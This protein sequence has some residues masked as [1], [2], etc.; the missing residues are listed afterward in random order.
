MEQP[1]RNAIGVIAQDGK[2]HGEGTSV[3]DLCLWIDKLHFGDPIIVS[4]T[5]GGESCRRLAKAE[6]I[7]YLPQ[8]GTVTVIGFASKNGTYPVWDGGQDTIGSITAQQFAKLK[9]W[10]L[11]QTV[12][13]HPCFALRVETKYQPDFSLQTGGKITFSLP[14]CCSCATC[15]STMDNKSATITTFYERLSIEMEDQEWLKWAHGSEQGVL[16]AISDGCPPHFPKEIIRRVIY[17]F[18]FVPSS[19]LLTDEIKRLEERV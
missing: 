1:E 6:V 17:T 9:T 16:S 7:K 4:I 3:Y 14:G 13:L 8:F 15:A 11:V 10:P 19:N 18:C 12:R 2:F 5:D